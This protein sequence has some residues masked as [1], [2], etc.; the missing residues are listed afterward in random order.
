M[1]TALAGGVGGARMLRGLVAVAG[2]PAVRAIVNTG[3]DLIIHGL[4]VSPDIDTVIYTLAGASHPERGWGLGQETWSGAE[5]LGRYGSDLGWFRLGDRDLATHLFRTGRLGAGA[6]L[7]EVTA[8]MARAW[9]LNSTVLPATNERL[10]T[11]LRLAHD[12]VEVDFQ[13]YFVRRAHQV[14]VSA[15]SFDGAETAQPAPGVIEALETAER[16]V[17]CPSNPMVSIAPILA[18]DGM[19]MAVAA[20]REATVAVSPIVAGA[21]LRGPAARLMRE[22]GHEV[23]VVGVARLY[24]PVAAT[25][26]LDT[27]DAAL[28]GRV[29][30]E[31][32]RAVVAPT[33]MS[34]ITSAIRLAEVVMRC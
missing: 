17:I 4:R 29:E 19:E 30:D 6:T 1:V 13:D 12:D 27:A 26:V 22:L 16:V 21:A 24:A 23:S 32:V 20:R 7:A 9:G 31:G 15:V 10:T 25:L 8:E 3:D 5:A 33:I 2:G 11:R 28:A 34:D 18:V 14:A